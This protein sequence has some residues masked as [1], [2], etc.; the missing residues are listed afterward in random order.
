MEIYLGERLII[1]SINYWFTIY[2]TLPNFNNVYASSR[3]NAT[4]FLNA[5]RYKQHM[6]YIFNEMNYRYNVSWDPFLSPLMCSG[7]ITIPISWR[8]EQKGAKQTFYISS[9]SPFLIDENYLFWTIG[10]MLPL[11]I[12][13][14]RMSVE[15]G[16]VSKWGEWRNNMTCTGNLFS[17]N[18][19]RKP[20]KMTMYCF[21]LFH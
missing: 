20:R 15:G 5:F 2:V 12:L 9:I 10:L 21:N 19:G 7:Y 3:W 4:Y 11:I 17:Q 16:E 13:E 14:P 8:K 18:R 1:I 6:S